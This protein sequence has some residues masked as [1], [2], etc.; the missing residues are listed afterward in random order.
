VKVANGSVG[1]VQNITEAPQT[2][3]NSQGTWQYINKSPTNFTVRTLL[4]ANPSSSPVVLA[5]NVSFNNTNLGS[6]AITVEAE[7]TDSNGNPYNVQ[8]QN[9]TLTVANRNTDGTGDVVQSTQQVTATGQNASVSVPFQVRNLPG[10]SNGRDSFTMTLPAFAT[11]NSVS[12][13]SLNAGG[14]SFQANNIAI[15][16]NGQT[17]QFDAPAANQPSGNYTL[18][19]QANLVVDANVGGTDQTGP[20]TLSSNAGNDTQ[21]ATLRGQFSRADNAFVRAS[22]R[23]TNGSPVSTAQQRVTA[24]IVE[25]QNGTTQGVLAENV[26]IRSDGFTQAVR[27]APGE[28]Y[29]ARVNLSLIGGQAA[30]F[31]FVSDVVT[32]R[33]N[34]T[35]EIAVTL[36]ELRFV[37]RIE[38]EPPSATAFADGRD[39]ATFTATVF[40]QNGNRFSGVP[41][42]A[43]PSAG[44]NAQDLTITPRT[45]RTNARGEAEFVVNSTAVQ[46]IELNFT[47]NLNAVGAL[48]SDQSTVTFIQN[49]EGS[50]QGTVINDATT[51]PVEDATAYAVLGQRFDS[52]SVTTNVTLPA[53]DDDGVIFVRLQD[54]ESDAI[55]D[56][57]DYRVTVPNATTTNVRKIDELNTTDA[58][59]GEGFAV[60]DADN[61]GNVT[62]THTVLEPSEY[63]ANVSLTASN[64]SQPILNNDQDSPESFGILAGQ[65]GVTTVR[66]NVTPFAPTANLTLASAIERAQNSG[67]NLVDSPG[68]VNTFGEDTDGTTA[69]GDFKLNKLFTNYQ[70][71]ADYVV[72]VTKAGFS[73]D[74][75]DAYVRED[76]FTFENQFDRGF[77]L[78]PEPVEPANVDIQQIGVR[79]NVSAPTEE[80]DNQS[81]PFAQQVPRDGQT[82]DVIEVTTTTE[83]GAPINGSAIVEIEDRDAFT[84]PGQ[85]AADN[86]QGTFIGAEGGNITSTSANGDTVTV[87]VGDDGVATL[88]LRADTRATDFLTNKT[89]TLANDLSETDRSAVLFVGVTRF[90]SASISGIVTDTNDDPIP[91]S[92]VWAQ[93]FQWAGGATRFTIQPDTNA[94][95][96]TAAYAEAVDDDSDPFV[97][98]LQDFNFTSG[99]YETVETDTATA[100]ELQNYEFDEFADISVVNVS[101]GFTLYDRAVDADASYTLEPVPA[102][103]TP[104][105]TEYSIQAVKFDAPFIGRQGNPGRAEVVPFTTDDAN[106]VIPIDVAAPSDNVTVTGLSAPSSV[107]PSESFQVEATV[108]N[109]GSAGTPADGREVE[110]RFDF[111]GDNVLEPGEV[112]ATQTVDVPAGETRTVTFDL[113]SSALVAAGVTPGDYTHGVAIPSSE[114]AQTAT[115]TVSAD[116]NGD[117]LVRD[118]NGDGQFTILDVSEFLDGFDDEYSDPASYDFNGDGQVTILDVSALLDEV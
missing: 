47:T 93:R 19:G 98:S 48:R 58:G 108:E 5:N 35:K 41:V 95:P 50:I 23:T 103:D 34:Q 53:A 115:I 79:D 13:I 96:G 104:G 17:I 15:G 44:Q 77:N 63:Y 25:V 88:L 60:I 90:Q 1:G 89:A 75:A 65:N 100:G 116:D 87:A 84:A 29:T 107:G 22:V 112:V 101:E 49:G 106:V 81:D 105:D 68:F 76:G 11:V 114:S 61:D 118:V 6:T 51:N 39:T 14:T 43:R 24:D 10:Q 86:F 54:N 64:T 38:V 45:N 31:S 42:T 73:T 97:V 66:Q 94:A 9:G 71:G 74:Y 91:D 85:P 4:G 99:E 26:S 83:D 46:S 110:F 12:S 8:T 69:T 55:L 33:S 59:V 80:F 28:Q 111:D 72:I 57:D 109:V 40:D 37:S 30:N 62:F 67:A 27:A 20:I 52:N 21:I 3:L 117:G 56:N 18:S 70:Q 102:A 78:E 82:I 36:L 32:A 16:P 2:S 92:A 7:V 113:N